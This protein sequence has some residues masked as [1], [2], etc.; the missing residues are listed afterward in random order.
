M[1]AEPIAGQLSDL[2]G[3][4]PKWRMRHAAY[5]VEPHLIRHHNVR[6]TCVGRNLHPPTAQIQPRH[7]NQTSGNTALTTIIAS[8]YG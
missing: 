2:L 1:E 5:G 7:L 8:P 4:G 3:Q 6:T